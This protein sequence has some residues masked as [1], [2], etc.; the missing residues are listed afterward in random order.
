MKRSPGSWVDVEVT[1]PESSVAV[2]SAH[3]IERLVMEAEGNSRVMSPGQPLMTGL[4][5]SLVAER[6]YVH[7]V[8]T[9]RQTDRQTEDNDTQ[10]HT[11]IH[12]TNN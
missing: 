4:V 3:D 6:V 2:G 11:D 12:C 8:Q 9:D 5:V 10:K 1:E 7:R